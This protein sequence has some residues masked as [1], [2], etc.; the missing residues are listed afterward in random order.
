ML[1]DREIARIE[2]IAQEQKVKRLFLCHLAAYVTL[3]QGLDRATLERVIEEEKL[4]EKRPSAGDPPDIAA[5]LQAALVNEHGTIQPIQPDMI[6]EALVLRVLHPHPQDHQNAVVLRAFGM[7]GGR[8]AATV[9]RTAQ[10]YA[11]AGDETPLA[12]LDHLAQAGAVNLSILMEIADQLP[13]NTLVLRERAVA[14]LSTIV[15]QA[16][17]LIADGND[18]DGTRSLLATSLN[19]VANHLSELGQREAALAAAQ[20]AVQL[21]R[22]LAAARPDAFQPAL[23]S[24]LNNVATFF[25]ELGQREAALAAAQEA[26]S[27]LAPFFLALPQAFADWM[28]VAARNYREYAEQL[29]QQPD[30]DLLLPIIEK[31]NA[32]QSQTGGES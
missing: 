15:T 18:T 7:A 6:G 3:C 27:L 8:V 28:V 29:N 32:L 5:A 19:N 4:A 21:Y 20:E 17:Q 22:P 23:A 12:W 2:A 1:A 30:A 11:F 25:S 14:I 9:I 16:R 13:L 26:V 31:L 10:D 24:S